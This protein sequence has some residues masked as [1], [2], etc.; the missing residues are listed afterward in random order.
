M[1][2]LVAP[3]TALA[4]IVELAVSGPSAS[5]VEQS[6]KGRNIVKGALCIHI[7]NKHEYILHEVTAQKVT[8][9]LSAIGRPS[10]GRAAKGIE[11]PVIDV[12]KTF[13][14]FDMQ[15]KQ[16]RVARACTMLVA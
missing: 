5:V 3:K 2:G 4:P 14:Y 7:E 8:A 13:G 9:T 6:L 16:E 10:D 1:T 15:K 11:I 12:A